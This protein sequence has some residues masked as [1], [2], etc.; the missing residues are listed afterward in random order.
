[1]PPR[2]SR[3]TMVLVVDDNWDLLRVISR[4]LEIGGYAVLTA[5]TG[6]DAIELISAGRTPDVVLT[7]GVMPGET[8]GWDLA[9]YV[10]RHF[11]DMPVVLMSGYV[12]EAE[13]RVSQTPEIDWFLP[14]PLRLSELTSELGQL[15]NEREV[16]A[17][18]AVG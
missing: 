7:D 12:G 15:L 2:K 8:Q 9:R 18:S 16:R 17:V 3:N 1:M 11:P 14:K 4:A 6:D 10:K 5:E 13:T